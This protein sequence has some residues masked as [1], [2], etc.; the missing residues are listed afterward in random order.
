M[1]DIPGLDRATV[2]AAFAGAVAYLCTQDKMPVTRALVYVFAGAAAAIYI[3]PGVIEWLTEPVARG[4]YGAV[5]GEKGRAA[6]I[7]A[8]G[9]GGIW[10]LN[11]IIALLTAAKEQASTFVAAAIAR[12]FNRGG[13]GK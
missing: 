5:I 1:E 13:D 6:I 4:G 2:L 8:T 7:F 10:L 12:I 3:A 9:V 11:L